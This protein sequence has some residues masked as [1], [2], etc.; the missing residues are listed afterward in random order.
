MIK[1]FI[2]KIVREYWEAELK[3]EIQNEVRSFR[4]GLDSRI[5]DRCAE[6]IEII[7]DKDAPVNTI[8]QRHTWWHTHQLQSNFLKTLKAKVKESILEDLSI[9]EQ[10]RFRKHIEGED[11]ITGIVSRINDKQIKQR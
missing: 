10:E 6:L 1:S 8:G 7:F 11:F 2:R 9:Q 4:S 3:L 5:D